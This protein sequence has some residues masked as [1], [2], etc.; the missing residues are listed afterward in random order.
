MLKVKVVGF[1]GRS[2]CRCLFAMRMRDDIFGNASV[3]AEGDK[4]SRNAAFTI[5]DALDIGSLV[6]LS[7]A[8]IC[9]AARAEAFGMQTCWEGPGVKTSPHCFT[10]AVQYVW[11]NRS[12]HCQ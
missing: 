7:C 10:V 8:R 4:L 3:G 5:V 9:D 1:M 6:L 11:P 2:P 12:E